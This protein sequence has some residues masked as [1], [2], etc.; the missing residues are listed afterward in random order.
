MKT[1]QTEGSPRRLCVAM[2]VRDEERMLPRCLE[3]LH[4]F[5]DEAVVLDTGSTDGT[6]ALLEAE[7][8]GDRFARFRWD[9]HEFRDFGSARQALL[10]AIEIQRAF[11]ARNEQDPEEPIRVRIGLH[12]GEVLKDSAKFFGKTVI[13]AARVAAQAGG[14]EIL[15][16]SLLKDLTQSVGDI[17]FGEARDAALKGISE[18]Q[19][20]FPVE[21]Q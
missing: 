10:C 19:R 2:I 1:S 7:A 15:V 14:G 16:S 3:S 18:I 12:T 8:A 21:W 9:R 17:R 6:I 5:V 13:L 11:A 20:L 4:G